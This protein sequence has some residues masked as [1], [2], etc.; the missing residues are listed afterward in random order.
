[1]NHI[2]LLLWSFP[3]VMNSTQR[4]LLM[5]GDNRN[6]L[7]LPQHGWKA[8]LSAR[9]THP[10][11]WCLKIIDNRVLRVLSHVLCTEFWVCK[12]FEINAPFI[13][14]NISWISSISWYKSTNQ[15]AFMYKATLSWKNLYEN[16]ISMYKA[17][18]ISLWSVKLRTLQ[19][20]HN[21]E[22]CWSKLDI[23]YRT[24]LCGL[25]T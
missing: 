24:T 20:K 17:P 18:S 14:V 6:Y 11:V 23:C 8:F 3:H 4:L 7:N 13:L 9:H 25:V 5:C 12:I 21:S 15:R 19:T 2:E 16:V 22:L 1:M 10:A